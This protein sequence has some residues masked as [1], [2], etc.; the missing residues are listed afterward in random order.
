[1]R[2]PPRKLVNSAAALAQSLNVDRS[3]AY[4]W[5]RGGCPREADGS[6]DVAAVAIWARAMRAFA[7]ETAVARRNGERPEPGPVLGDLRN[8]TAPGSVERA[9]ADGVLKKLQA[10]LKAEELKRIRGE[11]VSRAHVPE[12]LAQRMQMFRGALRAVA[13]RVS[14][15]IVNEPD[16]RKIQ[17][18]FDEAHDALLWECHGRKPGEIGSA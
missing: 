14:P 6:F 5:I 10:A 4:R 7:R 15:R 11:T 2:R 8:G 13:R 18:V 3:T 17:A 1:M 12:L 16:V 9:Q